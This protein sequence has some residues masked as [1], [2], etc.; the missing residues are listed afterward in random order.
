[1]KIYRI[2]FEENCSLRTWVKYGMAGSEITAIKHF[3]RWAKREGFTGVKIQSITYVGL[4][5]F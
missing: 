5:E 2:D 3:K 1:M 4:V